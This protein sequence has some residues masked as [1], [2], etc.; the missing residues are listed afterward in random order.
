M[1]ADDW[2]R[3]LQTTD[4][5]F[6]CF[7]RGAVSSVSAMVF[8]QDSGRAA[9]I[10]RESC[11]DVGL[12]LNFTT[13][14]TAPE[15]S[16]TLV[17]HQRRLSAYLR[18]SRLA[19]VFYHPGLARSFQYVAAAQSDEFCRLYGGQPGRFDGHHHM[20]LCTNVLVGRLLPPGIIVRRSFSFNPG[21]RSW[22]NR[23]YR[24]TVDR[25]LARR[26]R[27]TDF[28]FSLTPLEPHRLRRIIVMARQ[29]TVEIEAHPANPE[30]YQFL[31]GGGLKRLLA[32]HRVA[33]GFPL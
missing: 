17:E 26:H 3:D 27:L 10:A 8:M 23:L 32:N 31:I 28:F 12:H 5:A 1:N 33:Q 21:Q 4:R 14:F 20:H 9:A 16:S 2:G 7:Q 18:A 11:I 15:T 22:G 19:Q 6:Q 24:H 30:E 25:I 13:P 29:G